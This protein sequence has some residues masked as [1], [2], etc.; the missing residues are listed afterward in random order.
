M[1]LYKEVKGK[2]GW[3][4]GFKLHLIVNYKGEIAAKVTTGNLHDTKLVEEFAKGLAD[5]LYGD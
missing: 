5:Q 4:Y 3:F 2:V 1:V